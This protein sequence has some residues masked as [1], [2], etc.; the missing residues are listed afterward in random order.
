MKDLPLPK[1]T[2]VFFLQFIM[3][4]CERIKLLLINI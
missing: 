3:C 4:G 2:P 1:A